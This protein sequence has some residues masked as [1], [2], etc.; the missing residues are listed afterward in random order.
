MGMRYIGWLVA[1]FVLYRVSGA[2]EA[3]GDAAPFAAAGI[4]G[5]R[6][7]Y[8]GAALAALIAGAAC[9]VRG[10]YLAWRAIK[11]RGAPKPLKP[12]AP[13]AEAEPEFD[14]DAAFA[15]YMENRGSR[16]DVPT[17]RPGGF[18]RKGL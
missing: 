16:P 10:G 15:H 7:Q 8:H 5:E 13:D 9:F 1:G 3:M 4:S 18:G 14:P 2:L 11:D 17:S 12:K 6:L